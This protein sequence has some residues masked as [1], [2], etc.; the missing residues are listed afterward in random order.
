MHNSARFVTGTRRPMFHPMIQSMP[1][2][3]SIGSQNRMSLTQP[4][5]S[6]FGTPASS[7]RQQSYG[8]HDPMFPPTYGAP[9]SMLHAALHPSNPTTTSCSSSII[10]NPYVKRDVAHGATFLFPHPTYKACPKQHSAVDDASQRGPFGGTGGQLVPNDLTPSCSSSIHAFPSGGLSMFSIA[11]DSLGLPFTD[12]PDQEFMTGISYA[13]SSSSSAGSSSLIDLQQADRETTTEHDAI[14]ASPAPGL[15]STLALAASETL[16]KLPSSSHQ[17]NEVRPPEEPTTTC[18][19]DP[20]PTVLSYSTAELARFVLQSDN[21]YGTTDI[22]RTTR[23]L[24]T[25]T[26]R[27][28]AKCDQYLQMIFTLL[29]NHPSREMQYLAEDAKDPDTG[30]LTKRFWLHLSGEPTEAK[31]QLLNAILIIFSHWYRKVEYRGR[32]TAE[33]TDEE[34]AQVCPLILCCQS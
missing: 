26:T 23:Q 20:L 19:T 11:S 17:Q 14:H 27:H 3:P 16:T 15:L 13:A 6:S 5:G 32:N 33:M 1:T 29:A 4:T 18:T 8:A 21:L 31:K 28:K 12:P 7:F 25:V 10:K 2:A 9:R 34:I 30:L 24:E 22:T